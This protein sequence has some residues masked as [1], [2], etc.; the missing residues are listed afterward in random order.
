MRRSAPRL[1][2]IDRDA[3]ERAIA[4]ARAKGPVDR[5]QI[6]DKLKTEPWLDVGEF[7]AYSCQMDCLHLKPWQPTPSWVGDIKADLAA[8]DDGVGG[9]YA[10][11]LLLKK[12][13]AAG[14]S[15][16]EPDPVAAL[17]RVQ[18]PAPPT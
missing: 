9:Q 11:A 13:L 6:D 10:A 1:S 18:D 14:L 12:M 2:R 15:R 16:Y 17:E 5:E 7:A 8:G 3:L 4:M